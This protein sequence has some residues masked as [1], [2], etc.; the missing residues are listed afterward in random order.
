MNTRTITTFGALAVAAV[1]ALTGC[2]PSAD[3]PN[4]APATTTT[5]ASDSVTVADGWVKAAASGMSA[6]F[7]EVKNSGTKDV[8]LVS[9]TTASSAEAQLHETV[10]GAAGEMMMQ[11]KDG[12]FLIPAGGSFVLAPGGN[13]IMLMGL[14]D[15]IVAGAEVTFTLTFSDGSTYDFTVPAKDYSGAN[16]TYS[17]DDM[18][19]GDSTDMGK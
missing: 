12:G 10:A 5:S 3:A 15:P 1:I 18:G 14:V 17:G 19:M 6:A 9:A 7:G 2:A 4:T 8:T 11:Q 16:E 13:H